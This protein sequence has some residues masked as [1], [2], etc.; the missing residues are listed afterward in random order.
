[1]TTET[2]DKLYLE[3]SVLTSARTLREV[4]Q[5]TEIATLKA[6]A[7]ALLDTIPAHYQW[8]GPIENSTPGQL[9]AKNL[10]ALL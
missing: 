9:A 8:P 6:A 2:L 4:L 1:M 7:R 5:A 3:W 10:A